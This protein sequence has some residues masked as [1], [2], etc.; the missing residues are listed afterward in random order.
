MGNTLEQMK[1]Q[2]NEFY[3]SLN[4]RQKILIGVSGLLIISSLLLLFFLTARPEYV[5]LYKDL[6][7][8]DS[9]EMT[10]K[11]DEM[12]IPWKNGDTETTILVPKE[13]LNKAKMNLAVEGFPKEGFSYEDMLNNSSLTMTNDERNRRHLVALMNQLS[14]TV[15]EIDGVNK[16]IVNLTVA[17]NSNFLISQ[18]KSKAS[19]LVELEPG[20]V[21]QEDQIKGIV[22]IVSGAV[23]ELDP[24]N[25]SVVD[26]KGRVLNKKSEDNVFSA[27]TQMT[28]QQEVQNDLKSSIEQFLSTVYGPGN[29]AVL[30]NV[31]LDF[32]SEVSDAKEFAPPIPEETTGLI[33]SMN[34]LKEQVV[35]S[36]QGGIPGTDSN[37]EDITQYVEN[38]GD[39]STYD[40]ANTTIN[41]ELNEIRK[42]IV[43]AQGQ[44]K[45]ITVAVVVNKRALIDQEMTD[46]HRQEI[47]NLVS[48]SAGLDTRV[49]EVMA[50]DF[51]TTL[52]D[53]LANATGQGSNGIF[54]TIPIWAVALMLAML[55]G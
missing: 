47:I 49:V 26:N 35:N 21:L 25:I 55:L 32:D 24:E 53:Q 51:D 4:K 14:R 5:T 22:M 30:V 33:R 28:L 17:D 46:E 44:V 52:A 13:H 48:A 9:G 3:Q 40:K 38:S 16:A 43:K 11:L 36:P 37:I 6:S 20:K 18:Q 34:E 2:L 8:K 29:V 50:R 10:K 15:E 1:Q 19:V 45:D 54:D 41:Y 39:T 7:L 27:S 31:K 23:K 12:G 42:Q